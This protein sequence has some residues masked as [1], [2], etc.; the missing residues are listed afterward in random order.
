MKWLI[1]EGKWRLYGTEVA[2]KLFRRAAVRDDA[3]GQHWL[4]N[5]L[6]R[7]TLYTG[8]AR[9]DEAL[10]FFKLSAE[11]GHVGGQYWLALVTFMG[12]APNVRMRW[13]P[14]GS[15]WPRCRGS[16]VSL[17]RFFFEARESPLISTKRCVSPNWRRR[18]AIRTARR[19]SAKSKRPSS[20]LSV[21]KRASASSLSASQ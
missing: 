10:G 7:A 12:A 11:Q 15:S 21:A 6:F 13:R 3:N 5:T 18:R 17:N 1:A 9:F 20:S 14:N 2:L 4:G 16:I 19:W 8:Q